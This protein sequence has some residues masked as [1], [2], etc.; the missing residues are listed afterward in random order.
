MQ[1]IWR[2]PFAFA[3]AAVVLLAS[4]LVVWSF[5]IPTNDSRIEAIRRQG[6]PVTLR[7]LNAWY[8]AVPDPLNAALICTQALTGRLFDDSSPAFSRFSDKPWLPPRGEMLSA[9]DQEELQQILGGDEKTLELLHS[10]AAGA[11]S[12]YPID[13]SQGFS[14]LLPHL[15]KAKRGVQVLG[16]EAMMRAA[17]GNT[18]GAVESLL[19]AGRFT[20]TFSEE[21]IIISHL[22]RIACWDQVLARVQRLVNAAALDESQLVSLQKAVTTAEHPDSLA[23]ALAGE[24]AF[25]LGA[26]LDRSQRAGIFSSTGQPAS[27]GERLAHSALIMALRVS[28]LLQRDQAFYLDSMSNRIAA[29]SLSFPERYEAASLLSTNLPASRFLIFS[30]ML[31][32]GLSRLSVKDAEH[33]SRMRV[34]Q[35]T[36]AVERYRAANGGKPPRS[37]EELMP[38]YLVAIPSDPIDGKPLRFKPREQGYVVYAVGSN[39]KDDGGLELDPKHPNNSHD[40]TF[41]VDHPRKP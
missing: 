7:E 28:G 23:R 34:A 39:G 41:C 17:G 14:A 1:S 22:V 30:R 3:A 32:P 31:L 9:Q 12:R 38:R 24:R 5:L 15:S 2:N 21:P 29:A 36:L 16:A 20:E 6:Y 4:V 18:A 33:A 27:Q 11:P 19:A 40:I 26:F 13:L 25:G 37:L 8:R 10:I 35:A